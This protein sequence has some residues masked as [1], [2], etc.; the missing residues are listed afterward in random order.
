VSI[1][2]DRTLRDL[3]D[4]VAT[5][6]P[7]PAGVSVAAVSACL[8]LSLLRKVLEIARHRKDFEGDPVRVE[9]LLNQARAESDK[10]ERLAEE[11]IE[12]YREFMARR[13]TEEAPAALR[14][15]TEVPLEAA[16]SA[17]AG[18]ELCADS[19]AFVPASILPDYKTAAVLLSGAVRAIAFSVQANT[20]YLADEEL[21]GRIRHE[22]EA[23]LANAQRTLQRLLD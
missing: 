7:V 5:R 18:L 2:W 21:A 22:L 11:D 15:A 1:I 20:Q 4:N 17:F 14:R 13:K 16:R 6:D 8:G 23:M 9:E 10:L 3:R 12:A 19:N